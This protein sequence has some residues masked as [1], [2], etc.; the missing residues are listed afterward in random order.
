M[1]QRLV[2]RKVGVDSIARK[3]NFMNGTVI[4]EESHTLGQDKH[5]ISFPMS[6]YFPCMLIVTLTTAII[7]VD[8]G[9]RSLC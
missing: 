2:H 3:K 4:E 1:T 8:C 9:V 7:H 5:C 6:L